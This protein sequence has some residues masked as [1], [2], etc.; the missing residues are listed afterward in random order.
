[1]HPNEINFNPVNFVLILRSRDLSEYYRTSPEEPKNRIHQAARIE[2]SSDSVAARW[3]HCPPVDSNLV[4]KNQFLHLFL[5][6]KRDSE[7][8]GSGK[9]S[10][11]GNVEAC[12]EARG[13]CLPNSPQLSLHLTSFYFC[14]PPSH[15]YLL[16]YV[17]KKQSAGTNT[18]VQT[19]FLRNNAYLCR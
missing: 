17:H 8:A 5:L 7:A 10:M 16:R 2:L 14:H 13:L 12:R 11:Q 9:P 6:Q 3:R 18:S 4:T 15:T 1:M 19:C